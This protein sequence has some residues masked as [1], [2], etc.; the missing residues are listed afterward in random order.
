MDNDMSRSIGTRGLN[1]AS[2]LSGNSSLLQSCD[3]NTNYS[4]SSKQP[5]PII[6]ILRFNNSDMSDSSGYHV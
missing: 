1:Q 5:F 3:T 6:P 2:P 4:I